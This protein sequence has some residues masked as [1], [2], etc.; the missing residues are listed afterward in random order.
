MMG[1]LTP[2]GVFDQHSFG[3]SWTD[4]EASAVSCTGALAVQP[5]MFE[6]T[7]TLLYAEG[8]VR[9]LVGL[10]WHGASPGPRRPS[11]T[12]STAERSMPVDCASG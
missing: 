6:V 2:A 11:T 3:P 8:P 4:R 1:S 12:C 10:R 7:G 9:S 5:G